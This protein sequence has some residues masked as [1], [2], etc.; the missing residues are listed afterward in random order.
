[1]TKQTKTFHSLDLAKFIAALLVVLIHTAPLGPYSA[2]A[3]FYTRDVLARI[4]VPLFFAISGFFFDRRATPGKTFWRIARLYLGWS[5]VYLLLQLPQWYRAGWWGP[6]VILDYG[7]A[8]VFQGSYY[9]LWYLLAT[10]YAIVPLYLLVKRAKPRGMLAV[11][12]LCWLIECMTYSYAW[13]AVDRLPVLSALLDRFSGVCDGLFRALPLM[14][15]GVF[16]QRNSHTHSAAYWAKRSLV[17][18]LLLTAEAS[19]LYFGSPNR[20][21]YSYLIST[22]FFTYHFLCFLLRWDFRFRQAE[23]ALVLRRASLMIYCVHP[24]I[25]HFVTQ[26]AIPEGIPAWL[27]VTVLAGGSALVYSA[28]ALRLGRK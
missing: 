17:W 26:S 22:P 10:L 11:C 28:A 6:H 16:C 19:V 13:L 25:D 20:Q 15:V 3:N 24:L 9:H 18:F 14:L 23:H 27:A 12:G 7:L 4:A 5:A 2:V 21:L 8:L 1:M